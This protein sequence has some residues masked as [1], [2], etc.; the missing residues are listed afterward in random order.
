MGSYHLKGTYQVVYKE[1][2]T[3]NIMSLDARENKVMT[4][5]FPACS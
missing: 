3:I 4:M 2:T 1:S 5:A